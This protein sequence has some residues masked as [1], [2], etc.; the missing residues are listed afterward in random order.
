MLANNRK[1][2]FLLIGFTIMIIIAKL[3]WRLGDVNLS[4]TNHLIELFILTLF[5]LAVKNGK[6]IFTLYS[7][8]IYGVL[9]VEIVSLFIFLGKFHF[10]TINIIL[11]TL[12]SILTIFKL[13]IYTTFLFSGSAKPLKRS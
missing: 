3:F 10:S 5:G 1:V 6:V 11:F 9:V 8:V 13:I 4:F 12:I 2:Q 7:F